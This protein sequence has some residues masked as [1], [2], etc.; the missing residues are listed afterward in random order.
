MAL[1]GYSGRAMTEHRPTQHSAG[2]AALSLL[3]ERWTYLIVR[4]IFF[5]VRRFG[6]IQRA[7]GIAPN[8]LTARLNALVEAGVLEKR[9]Y[10]VDPDWFEYHLTDDAREIAP[11]LLALAQWAEEHVGTGDTMR[12]LR[13][14]TCGHLT[15]PVLACA[16]C[17]EPLLAKDL[18]PEVVR[19]PK[20]PTAA[21]RVAGVTATGLRSGV[22]KKR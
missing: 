13:H 7:I 18:L 2:A 6:Q 22:R 15:H 14:T 1:S 17:A 8:V 21:K 11:A 4:E 16:H 5:E 3:G 10:H 12:A 9:R 19:R 20:K